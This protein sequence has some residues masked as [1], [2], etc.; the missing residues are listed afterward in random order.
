MFFFSFFFLAKYL[1][2]CQ[3]FIS[4]CIHCTFDQGKILPQD[5][6]SWFLLCFWFN[7][8]NG[9]FPRVSFLTLRTMHL[10]VLAAGLRWGHC[11]HPAHFCWTAQHPVGEDDILA[12]AAVRTDCMA[13]GLWPKLVNSSQINSL[14]PGLAL[15]KI[16]P[17]WKSQT[18]FWL[19][20]CVRSLYPLT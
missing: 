14:L 9:E 11:K 4:L 1:V 5:L 7:P 6:H 16:L 19:L 18:Y 15:K 13:A 3:S 12:G 8:G 2:G 10:I 17:H 20:I